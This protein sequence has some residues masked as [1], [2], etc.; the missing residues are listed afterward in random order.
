MQSPH[1]KLE[2]VQDFLLA[3]GWRIA[4]SE[5]GLNYFNPPAHLTLDEP[6]QIKVPVSVEF[7]GY[8][9]YIRYVLENIAAFYG[10]DVELLLDLF[11]YS[12][13]EFA[14]IARLEIAAYQE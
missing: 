6:Y 13:E 11:S 4:K 10:L 7:P 2:T 12:P 14:D 3:K 8:A 5:R 9:R 1:P